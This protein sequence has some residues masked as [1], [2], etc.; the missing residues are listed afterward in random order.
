[1]NF[2][3]RSAT[4]ARKLTTSEKVIIL[5]SILVVIISTV[6]PIFLWTTVISP[7]YA[8]ITSEQS[9]EIPVPL[10]DPASDKVRDIIDGHNALADMDVI[11][12]TEPPAT[13]ISGGMPIKIKSMV[14]GGH[15][16]TNC[17]LGPVIDA[18]RALTAAHCP[19]NTPALVF[20]NE[21]KFIGV[22]HYADASVIDATVIHFARNIPRSAISVNRIRT[23]KLNPGETL[24]KSGRT[25]GTIAGTL[26]S[27][28]GHTARF[29][30]IS[31]ISL[32]SGGCIRSGDSGGLVTDAQGQAVGIASYTPNVANDDK[33]PPGTC[34]SPH[35]SYGF[36]PI[37]D[38]L[39][40]TGGM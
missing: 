10:V 13:H 21:N 8:H 35:P 25:T 16:Y 4:P 3:H 9:A 23:T 31:T 17:S 19:K 5:L 37:A 38:A 24:I 27:T 18:H 11:V 20:D 15:I 2:F 29:G 40:T 1:M 33:A 14:D 30:N 7:K 32:T 34:T 6:F 22:I 39:V 36:V 12:P 28:E 26:K